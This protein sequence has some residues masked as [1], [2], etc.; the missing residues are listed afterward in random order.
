VTIER[1]EEGTPHRGK[2]VAVVAPHGDDFTIFCGGTVAKLIREGYTGYLIRT[3]NDEIDSYDLPVH[4][5]I[6]RNAEDIRAAAKLLG[7]R[8][9]IDLNLRI[10]RMEDTPLPALRGTLIHLY[11]TLRVNAIFTYDP[12]DVFEGN[13]DHR[14]TARAAFEAHWIAT[15]RLDYPEHR[16]APC[17][18]PDLYF[19]NRYVPQ[20]IN[21]VVDI[22]AT[23]DAKLA[24]IRA[25][26]TQIAYEALKLRDQLAQRNLR[27]PE[28]GDDVDAAVRWYVELIRQGAAAAGAKHG[29]PYAERFRFQSGTTSILR[30]PRFQRYLDEHAVPLTSGNDR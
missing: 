22:S 20:L 14:Y 3:T 12:A 30:S 13:P 7:V 4:E 26:R 1:A 29:L 11:R 18:R 6:A 19:F 5:T 24:A 16:V 17:A 21:R 23:I 9:V 15:N 28:L 2:V 25:N 27:L 8:E 10:H